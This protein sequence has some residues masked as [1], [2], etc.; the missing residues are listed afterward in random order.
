M[1]HAEHRLL[2]ITDELLACTGRLR[3]ACEKA[4]TPWPN[5]E[6]KDLINRLL[7]IRNLLSPPPKPTTTTHAN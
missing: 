2:T 4:G 7:D 6:A 3:T 5:R 1:N